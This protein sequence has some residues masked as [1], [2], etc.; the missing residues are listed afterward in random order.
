MCGIAGTFSQDGA[1]LSHPEALATMLQLIHHRG[2]DGEGVFTQPWVQLGMRRLSII[3]LVTGDQPMFSEDGSLVLVFNGEIYNYRELRQDLIARGHIFKTQAD[4]EV[5]VHLYEEK[6]PSCLEDLNGMFAFA[7]YDRRQHQLFLAR[8]RF[9]KKPLFYTVR[10]REVI[11]GSELKS[12]LRYPGVERAVDKAALDNLLAFNFVP[13]PDTLYQGIKRLHAGSYLLCRQEEISEVQFWT[14]PTLVEQPISEARAIEEI[15]S[16]LSDAVRIRMRSDVPVGAFL[17][18]GID[19]STVTAYMRRHTAEPLATFSIG[20][21]EDQFSEL[22]YSH[23]MASLLGTEHHTQVMQHEAVFSSLLPVLWHLDMPHGDASFMPTYLVSSLASRFV[24]V[25][26]TGDGGDELFAGYEKYRSFYNGFSG[27]DFDYGYF[28]A[29][30]ILDDGLRAGLYT[31]EFRASL[32]GNQPFDVMRKYLNAAGTDDLINRMLYADATLL[33][34]GNNLV[35]PDRMAMAVSIEP[36]APF[37]DYRLAEYVSRLPGDWKL[38]GDTLKFILKK[39]V[40]GIIPDEV[41]HRKKQMF[42]VPI[43]EWFRGSLRQFIVELMSQERTRERGYFEPQKVDRMVQDHLEGRA[44]Y[45]RQLRLLMNLELWHRMFIDDLF[46]GPPS[47]AELG[48]ET[49]VPLGQRTD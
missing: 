34:E 26:L 46:D 38:R 8:D 9:G 5:V 36:R 25:V 42:T 15:Q 1:P 13:Q 22:P 49:V 40:T 35:K 33:L 37:L 23:L 31:H 48:L 17:S 3:D 16:L 21:G 4:T 19:S 6:G 20:F 11:F 28:Q 14:L 18:G 30:S 27:G 47:W 45:T 39:A 41:I 10:G 43:G 44:N 29:S 12:L 32:G 2:P 7:L 24:K